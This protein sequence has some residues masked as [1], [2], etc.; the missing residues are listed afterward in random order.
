MKHTDNTQKINLTLRLTKEEYDVTHQYESNSTYSNAE[1]HATGELTQKRISM[2][3]KKT[4]VDEKL[5]VVHLLEK[6]ISD[7]GTRFAAFL[8]NLEAEG[9]QAEASH[10]RTQ[11]ADACERHRIKIE[12]IRLRLK[13]D[14]ELFQRKIQ[15]QRD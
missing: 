13:K 6:K 10:W 9:R 3:H 11:V 12:E 14:I 7:L 5:A 8:E 2:D 15:E 4:S 1:N